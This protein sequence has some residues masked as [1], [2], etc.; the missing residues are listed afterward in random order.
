MAD[1]AAGADHRTHVLLENA[2]R[3]LGVSVGYDK[4]QLPCFTLWKNTGAPADGYVTGL[5]PATNYPNPRSFEKARGRV[6]RLDPGQSAAFD[7]SLTVHPDRASVAAAEKAVAALAGDKQTP[8][9][10]N[11]AARL[12]HGRHA[13]ITVG[14]EGEH[15]LAAPNQLA[16]SR[17]R[18]LRHATIDRLAAANAISVNDPGSGTSVSAAP[19]RFGE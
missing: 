2:D 19:T 16:R 9:C 8:R 5:E 6:V 7:V 3:S 10:P 13:A 15:L 17:P 14:G 11:A 12:E 4:R 18:R 1:L